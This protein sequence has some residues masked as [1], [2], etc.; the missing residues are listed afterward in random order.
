MAYRSQG[1]VSWGTDASG[2][3]INFVP[4]GDYLVKDG[5]RSYA[6][7][8]LDSN[9]ESCIRKKCEE[10]ENGYPVGTRINILEKNVIGDKLGDADLTVSQILT[11]V[12]A[13][14][15]A[16]TRSKVQV[17]VKNGNGGVLKL[18]GITVPAQ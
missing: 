4:H 17:E 11:W 10:D 18:M 5:G 12:A 8:L 3:W 7:F 15:A 1:T 9:D 14:S 16:M 6:V 13:Q 2:V